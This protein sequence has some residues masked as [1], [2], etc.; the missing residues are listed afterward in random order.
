MLIYFYQKDRVTL[1]PKAYPQSKST[2]ISGLIDRY[3]IGIEISCDSNVLQYI[4]LKKLAVVSMLYSNLFHC[5][6][7]S[8]GTYVTI[9]ISSK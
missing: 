9:F 2:E 7:F 4:Q 5:K 8:N 3:C 1:P 6:H